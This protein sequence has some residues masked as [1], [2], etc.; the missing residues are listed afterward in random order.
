MNLKKLMLVALSVSLLSGV[1]LTGGCV[2]SETSSPSLATP[3][4][5]IENITPQDAFTMI[6]ENEGNPD[7]VILDV[8]TAEEF[9]DGHLENAVNIDYY[10]PGI[11]NELDTL[12]KNKNYLVYCRSGSRSL[13]AAKIMEELKFSNINNILDGIIRWGSEGLPIVR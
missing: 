6:G 1:F 5:L 2:G 4:Q 9:A 7:F 12:D 3:P 13:N 11:R 10:S 8:R